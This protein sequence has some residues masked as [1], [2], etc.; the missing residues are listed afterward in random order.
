MDNKDGQPQWQLTYRPQLAGNALPR[1]IGPFSVFAA[2]GL[3]RM[4]G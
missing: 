2:G 4:L 1:S 3:L